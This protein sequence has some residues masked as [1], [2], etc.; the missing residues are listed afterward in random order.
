M[1]LEA[2]VPSGARADGPAAGAPAPARTA[3]S[4]PWL[5]AIVESIGLAVV[6]ADARGRV[7]LMNPA[8]EVVTGCPRAQALGRPLGCVV[9]LVDEQGQPLDPRTVDLPR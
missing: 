5:A 3:G 2:E 6:A 7:A 4:D 8:A 9:R 1:S